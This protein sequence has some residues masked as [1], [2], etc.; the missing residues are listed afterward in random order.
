MQLPA[1]ASCER[2]DKE[3]VDFNK[4]ALV[5]KSSRI[6]SRFTHEVAKNQ[7]S[8]F[9]DQNSQEVM[10]SS[11]LSDGSKSKLIPMSFWIINLCVQKSTRPQ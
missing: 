5:R 9:L 10:I 6:K 7:C 1:N 3:W 4:Q 11:C 8:C 2:Y